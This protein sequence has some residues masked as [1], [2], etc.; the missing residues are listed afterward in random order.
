MGRFTK[1]DRIY[2]ASKGLCCECGKRP[3][4]PGISSCQQCRDR[5]KELRELRKAKKAAEQQAAGEPAAQPARRGR[6]PAQNTAK[7]ETPSHYQARQDLL[8]ITV[9]P[10]RLCH[11]CKKVRTADYRCP[12]CQA[13][14]KQR[15]GGNVE[16]AG[17][18]SPDDYGW[19]V[20]AASAHFTVKM[21]TRA[22]FRE[23]HTL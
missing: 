23:G 17:S 2:L 4:V 15:H 16:T 6:K 9:K 11:D 20:S 18:Y 8:D 19:N 7:K 3:S 21:Q 10:Q 14:H 1:E 5:A 22:I 12:A 13:K